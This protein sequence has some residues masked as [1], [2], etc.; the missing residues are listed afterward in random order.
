MNYLRMCN[1]TREYL[2]ILMA[3]QNHKTHIWES[4]T[5]LSDGQ[6]ASHTGF[7]D[8]LFKN[9]QWNPRVGDNKDKPKTAGDKVI[10]T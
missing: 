1:A 4:H 9:G 6:P 10:E 5:I 3:Q 7:K 8:I 2:A